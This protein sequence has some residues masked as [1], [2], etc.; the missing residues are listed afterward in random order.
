[1]TTALCAIQ[2]QTK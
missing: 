2:T 1:M